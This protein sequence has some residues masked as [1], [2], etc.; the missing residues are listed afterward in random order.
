MHTSA[1]HFLFRREGLGEAVWTGPSW[2]GH[3]SRQQGFLMGGGL[4]NIT[5]TGLGETGGGGWVFL[6]SL[7]AHCYQPH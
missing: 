5:P 6:S 4:E 2:R 1:V 7:P 3:V